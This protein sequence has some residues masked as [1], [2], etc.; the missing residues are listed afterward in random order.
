[1]LQFWVGCDSFA[2]IQNRKSSIGTGTDYALDGRC[3]FLG[4]N[5]IFSSG[6]I[7]Q[8]T[9]YLIDIESILP[10]GKVA[11][12]WNISHLHLVG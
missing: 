3:S 8:Q 1:V 5:E 2:I 9:F 7:Y 6:K 4:R 10:D 12:M 11:G